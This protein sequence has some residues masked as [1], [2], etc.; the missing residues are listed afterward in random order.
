VT[1]TTN[2]SLIDPLPCELC[3]IC[4]LFNFQQEESFFFFYRK[5]CQS[6]PLEDFDYKSCLKLLI[7]VN[8]CKIREIN[9]II[10]KKTIRN[11]KTT[12]PTSKE[13]IKFIRF[14]SLSFVFSSTKQNVHLYN[15]VQPH[16]RYIVEADS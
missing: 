13:D 8:L 5:L 6:Y 9:E 1:V 12:I 4:W 7:S 2:C 10:D 15:I 3:L 14:L 16:Q 11:L